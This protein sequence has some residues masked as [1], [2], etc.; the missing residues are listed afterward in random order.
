MPKKNNNLAVKH[1]A[2]E[3]QR[4]ENSEGR[5]GTFK[6]NAPFENAL[7]KILES[8]HQSKPRKPRSR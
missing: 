8:P 1:I 2:S 3:F 5:K 7:S 6:I 4:I